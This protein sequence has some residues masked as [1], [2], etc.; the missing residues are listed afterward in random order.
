[1]RLEEA[2][3]RVAEGEN[4]ARPA[5]PAPAPK[6]KATRSP[7]RPAAPTVDPTSGGGL[8]GVW[9]SAQHF[10]EPDSLPDAESANLAGVVAWADSIMAFRLRHRL[11]AR[12]DGHGVWNPVGYVKDGR[13]ETITQAQADHY[14]DRRLGTVAGSEKAKPLTE[15]DH[16]LETERV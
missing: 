12:L 2:R 4:T 14:R 3:R 9:R 8:F 1:M 13:R 6:K 5:E 16:P 10:C 11:I 7:S 15:R